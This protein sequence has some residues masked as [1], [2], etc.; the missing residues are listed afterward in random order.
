[1]C[2]RVL[3]M[4]NLLFFVFYVN[5]TS[6]VAVATARPSMSTT[7]AGTCSSFDGASTSTAAG[8]SFDDGSWT[9]TSTAGGSF[10]GMD[11]NGDSRR[12]VIQRL[13]F[14]RRGGN[15]RDRLL[16]IAIHEIHRRGH[17]RRQCQDRFSDYPS[18]GSSTSGS[19]SRAEEATRYSAA[20]RSSPSWRTA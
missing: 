16:D 18:P 15:C 11:F 17:R 12:Q 2:P 13:D 1:M 5:L 8:G 19:F 7:G 3:V 20:R 9:F 6:F 14:L 10:D 4:C